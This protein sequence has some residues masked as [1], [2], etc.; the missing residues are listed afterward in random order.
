[1]E[2]LLGFAFD[3]DESTL[4]INVFSSGCTEK[5]DFLFEL[6]DNVLTIYRVR[7]DDCKAI[8]MMESLTYSLKELGVDFRK[9]FIIAN[10]FITG[11]T[12]MMGGGNG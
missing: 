7:R 12:I 8:P 2:P 11:D 10:P 9:P 4:T 3:P 5:K 6:R 1:V